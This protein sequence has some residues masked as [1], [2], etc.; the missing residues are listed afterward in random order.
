MEHYYLS[1]LSLPLCRRGSSCNFIYKLRGS[2]LGIRLDYLLNFPN[3]LNNSSDFRFNSSI[4]L[5][6]ISS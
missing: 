6:Y 1:K 2:K 3:D 4:L 5:L